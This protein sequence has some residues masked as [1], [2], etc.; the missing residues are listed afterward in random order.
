MQEQL[1][2]ATEAVPKGLMLWHSS[3]QNR[4]ASRTTTHLEF[5]LDHQDD[6]G[7]IL[8][9]S[10]QYFPLMPDAAICDAELAVRHKQRKPWKYVGY[11]GFS[12]FIVSDHDFFMLR[13]FSK[14]TARVLLMLQDEIVQL[15]TN[16]EDLD[17][18]LSAEAATDVHNGSFREET[19]E[20]SKGILREMAGKL[21]DYNELVLQHSELRTR[22]GVSKKDQRSLQ[23]WFYNHDDQ[24]ILPQEA[25]FVNY[26]DDLF[27]VVA[28]PKTPLRRLL[29][30]SRHFRL[31]KLW[32]TRPK[33]SPDENIHYNS[34]DR[35]D[36]F[37]SVV[38]VVI[39]LLMLITPLWILGSIAPVKERLAII[40]A[41][42]MVFL[43][44]VTFTTAARPFESLGAAAA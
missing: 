34:Y 27:S 25:A 44:L 38:I 3:A 32:Q 16:L 41:F 29:E 31:F 40:T 20:E 5:A 1:G 2:A 33:G 30:R 4:T 19:S 14:I 15:E 39:G 10:K 17:A 37:V 42:L 22:L 23:N 35:I 13:A 8:L 11:P 18:K 7:T 28:R 9:C 12:E 43:C 6:S 36:A 24:A 21:R 26:S